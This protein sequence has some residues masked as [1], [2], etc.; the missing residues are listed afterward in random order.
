MR[1]RPGGT[2]LGH[3]ASSS[4]CPRVELK[5]HSK[6]GSVSPAWCSSWR[7]TT[8]SLNKFLIHVRVADTIL[9]PSFLKETSI[10]LLR[11]KLSTPWSLFSERVC[12]P[13]CFLPFSS[14][15]GNYRS[16]GLIPRL[17]TMLDSPP[18][19]RPCQ[20]LCTAHLS[21]N[22]IS[23]MKL[24]NILHILSEVSRFIFK[25]GWVLRIWTF[26]LIPYG[27]C[28]CWHNKNQHAFLDYRHN[29]SSTIREGKTEITHNTTI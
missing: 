21:G 8:S 28:P 6:V 4:A 9:L 3:R 18:I 10:L 26:Y 12:T 2:E 24:Q 5:H 27:N 1:T 14:P 19:C 7:G 17:L 29:S 25:K 15:A 11:L 23:G 20:K 13:Q 16:K 22:S